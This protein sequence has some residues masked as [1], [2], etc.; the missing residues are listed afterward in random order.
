MID[1]RVKDWRNRRVG[2]Q[3]LVGFHLEIASLIVR[4]SGTARS[5]GRFIIGIDP[6]TRWFRECGAEL[7][8]AVKSNVIR[9][10]SRQPTIIEFSTIPRLTC[11]YIRNDTAMAVEN[12]SASSD[13]IGQPEATSPGLAV[14]PEANRFAYLRTDQLSSFQ[15]E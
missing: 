13:W 6:R 2:A 7:R 14:V 3:C 8:T 11:C 1:I 5:P 10:F 12:S 4:Y 15:I 9:E